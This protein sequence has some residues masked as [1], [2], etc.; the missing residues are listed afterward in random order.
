M[1]A[2]PKKLSSNPLAER[3]IQ[4]LNELDMTAYSASMIASG[5]RSKQWINNILSGRS[6]SPRGDTLR[7]IADVLQTTTDFLLT[8][9]EDGQ[10]SEPAARVSGKYRNET[11]RLT[12]NRAELAKLPVL[13]QAGAA[14]TGAL[15][16]TDPIG[17]ETRPPA[18]ESVPDAYA[19]Y[20]SGDS[21]EPRYFS[22][23][24]VYVHP[25]RPF[26]QGDDVIVQIRESGGIV[27]YLKRFLRKTDEFIVC[28]QYNNPVGG[29]LEIKYPQRNVVAVHRVIN[30]R[31]L[32]QV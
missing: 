15:A 18:L 27:G 7:K 20:V 10:S 19:V 28:T 13:G 4:R 9:V 12:L 2:S 22:G 30:G 16:I 8:G 17:Y 3:I 23:E 21:M 26:R 32:M 11:A 31:E 5:G 25:R 14:I 6:A 24:M 1:P 29:A